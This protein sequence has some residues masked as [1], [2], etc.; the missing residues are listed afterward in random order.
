MTVPVPWPGGEHMLV[1]IGDIGVSQSAVSTPS[2]SAPVGQTSFQFADMSVTREGIPTW[3]VVCTIVFF[4]FCFLGLLFLLVKEQRT[5]G[6][7]QIVVQGPGLLHTAQLPVYS[8]QQVWDYNQ[9]VNY[10][11][12]LSATAR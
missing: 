10:A 8:Q 4:V 7:V 1:T 12:S 2:G 3:A 5:E 9:R 11:R 6:F